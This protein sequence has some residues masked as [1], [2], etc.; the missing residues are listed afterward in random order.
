M[1]TTNK[2]Y[3]IKT[4]ISFEKIMSNEMKSRILKFR[5]F[6]TSNESSAY[7]GEFNSKTSN[8][9]FFFMIRTHPGPLIYGQKYFPIRYWFRRDIRS[10]N[11]FDHDGSVHPKKDFALVSILLY[12]LR[13][14][15]IETYWLT[16]CTMYLILAFFTKRKWKEK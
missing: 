14:L 16:L 9:I 12:M 5:I 1:T 3:Y 10:W 4:N 7:Y 8:F 13:I 2:S 6:K 15:F 11:L